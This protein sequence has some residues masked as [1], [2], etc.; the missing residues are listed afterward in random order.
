M[1]LKGWRIANRYAL[2][3]SARLLAEKGEV[4]VTPQAIQNRPPPVGPMQVF[5]K[6]RMAPAVGGL[7]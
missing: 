1:K 4:K 6:I 5:S 3:A 2:P 7:S